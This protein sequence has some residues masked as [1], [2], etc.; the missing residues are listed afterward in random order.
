[1]SQRNSLT[2][3]E[4]A[5][6]VG[7]VV[8][9]FLTAAVQLKCVLGVDLT[10]V[11]FVLPTMVGAVMGLGIVWLR[12]IQRH[13]Q[14]LRQELEVRAREVRRLNDA[15][16]KRVEHSAS[17][18]EAREA[19]LLQSQK[20]EALGRL[21]GGIAH[22]FNNLLTGILQGAELIH[23]TSDDPELVRE[24][25]GE[26]QE[27]ADRAAKLTARLLSL[28]R[29]RRVPEP[30]RPIDAAEVIRGLERLI[31]RI[32]G[33]RSVVVIE[34][35]P[36]VPSILADP[37][38]LEQVVVN[39]CVNARDA[40]PNGGQLGIRLDQVPTERLPVELPKPSALGAVRLSVQDSGCGIPPDLL[41]KVFEPLFTT[42]EPGAGTGL[43]LSIV[44]N[45]VRG[46]GGTVHLDSIPGQGT[47][48]CLYWPALG[49]ESL[50]NEAVESAKEP[51]QEVVR[52]GPQTILV[53]D[54][55][56]AVRQMVARALELRGHRVVVAEDGDAAERHVRAQVERFDLILSDIHMPGRTGVELVPLWKELQ[57]DAQVVLMTGLTTHLLDRSRLRE[58]GVAKVLKKPFNVASLHEVLG[59]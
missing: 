35:Q 12:R 28:S 26:L 49:P 21:A 5:V 3:S 57:P 32:M 30:L 1:M 50:A 4:V 55:D 56:E 44:H 48:F 43:G 7:C 59:T 18:L 23:E 6:V 29:R 51:T 11:L 52:R 36:G 38:H 53:I 22:D 46:A 34:L 16:Q 17:Q 9:V 13:D 27:S 25:A 37:V 33:D 24:L 8:F 58:L 2:A 19:E 42:K 20:M 47:T 40:M 31:Q 45:L 15:L 14:F 41:D 39:L 10:P 54:D